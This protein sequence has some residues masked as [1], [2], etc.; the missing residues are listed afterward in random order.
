MAFDT[1]NSIFRSNT[2][3][4]RID[5]FKRFLLVKDD[6]LEAKN[7]GHVRPQWTM[8][9]WTTNTHPRAHLLKLKRDLVLATVA[10]LLKFYFNEMRRF[11]K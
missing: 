3:R 11:H 2:L 7:W 4:Q 5:E 10:K 9:L 6:T 1:L 8:Q